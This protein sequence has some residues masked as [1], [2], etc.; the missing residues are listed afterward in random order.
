[1]DFSACR[2]RKAF[3]L[4]ELLVVLAI[5]GVL[6][7]LTLAGVQAARTAAR[8]TQS[9]SNLRQLAL[10]DEMAAESN[11]NNLAKWRAAAREVNFTVLRSP[12]DRTSSPAW[13]G[14]V[15]YCENDFLEYRNRLRGVARRPDLEDGKSNTILYCEHYSVCGRFIFLLDGTP[16]N[17]GPNEQVEDQLDRVPPPG[18]QPR[19][20]T[21]AGAPWNDVVPVNNQRVTF[22][23]VRGKTFQLM[24]READCDASIPQ[25]LQKGGLLAAMHDSSVRIIHPQVDEQVF[26]SA[27]TPHGG[28]GP[29]NW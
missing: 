8:T 1:M 18:D 19:P 12:N 7:G 28:E 25:A 21:F 5:I 23:S 3:S 14:A 13:P 27:V 15:S 24:P 29:P 11:V 9:K 16:V 20:N 4:V 2:A 17:L 22:P 26:W 10:A 6:V